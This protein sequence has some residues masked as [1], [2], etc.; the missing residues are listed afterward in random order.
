MRRTNMG[1]L[2]DRALSSGIQ[3]RENRNL[4]EEEIE[5]AI[6][7]LMDEVSINQCKKATGREGAAIYT[8]VSRSLKEAYRRGLLLTK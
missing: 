6:A 4:N 2:I 7:W 1:R 5:L 8:L 3:G